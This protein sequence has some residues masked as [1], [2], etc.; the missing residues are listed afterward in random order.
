MY[1]DMIYHTNNIKEGKTNLWEWC[2]YTI[3]TNLALFRLGCYKFKILIIPKSD[4]Q[5]SNLKDTEKKG[6]KILHYKKFNYIA[7]NAVIEK[8]KS[9]K[10]IY[11]T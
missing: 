3:E 2:W 6:I 10:S 1:E 4:H 9:K 7:K 5:E 11:C 8:L